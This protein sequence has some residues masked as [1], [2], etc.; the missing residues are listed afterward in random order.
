MTCFRSIA[1]EFM[2]GGSEGDVMVYADIPRFVMGNGNQQRRSFDEGLNG[3]IVT[4]EVGWYF[5]CFDNQHIDDSREFTKSH[6]DRCTFRPWQD[7]L[8]GSEDM[9]EMPGIDIPGAMM[10]E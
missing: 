1:A 4:E 7:H 5:S 3:K 8:H 6:I 10:G 9:Q 2:T